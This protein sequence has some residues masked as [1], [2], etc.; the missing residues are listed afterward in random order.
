MKKTRNRFEAFIF[1][2]FLFSVSNEIF[3]QKIYSDKADLEFR[4][5]VPKWFSAWNLVSKEV[6][7]L[8]TFDKVD[9]I[10]FNEKT[11]YSTSDITIPNGEKILIP[12]IL[13]YS[14]KWKKDELKENIM[15]PNGKPVEVGLMSF[16]SEYKS[17]NAKSF[18][19][20]PLP[21][22]W[23][24]AG[25]SSKELGDDNLIT[26]IFTHEFSHSQQ[27]K[28]FGTKISE[29]EKLNNFGID[30]SD[31]IVQNL[32]KDNEKYVS[33]YLEEIKLLENAIVENNWQ[34]KKD[35]IKKALSHLKMRQEKFFVGKYS[36]LIEIDNLF[37]TMEGL[38]QFTMYSWLVNKKGA[39]LQKTAAIDGV[40]RKK[41]QWS[42]DEGFLL[43]LLLEQLSSPRNWG[44]SMF[45]DKIET[46]VQLI[47]K[48]LLSKK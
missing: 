32:F 26:G 3:G 15:L 8:K 45:G 35:L 17:K 14:F 11:L 20:M 21:S 30:F 34:I 24:Q 39:N 23:K 6:Y 1:L 46:V 41:N 27:I 31:D 42:Q 4:Q 5:T 22:F 18:F 37:L 38:G 40:R 2:V 25:V 44:N 29:F 19:V 7:G 33:V 13:P 16:A 9:F 43:F 12:Q 47:E 36:N 10:L 28:N 48:Y